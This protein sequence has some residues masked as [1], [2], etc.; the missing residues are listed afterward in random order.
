MNE[1][2]R[3]TRE[4]IAMAKERGLSCMVMANGAYAFT[5]DLPDIMGETSGVL[6]ERGWVATD[7]A[8]RYTFKDLYDYVVGSN[9]TGEIMQTNERT[10]MEIELS[11]EFYVAAQAKDPSVHIYQRTSALE[12]ENFKYDQVLFI[13]ILPNNK[14]CRIYQTLPDGEINDKYESKLVKFSDV[15][16]QTILPDMPSYVSA[17][18]MEFVMHVIFCW[19]TGQK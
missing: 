1:A 5:G 6:N 17:M 8:K 3:F 15:I 13:R 14:T 10:V 4:V 12:D 2:V 11:S 7:M 18:M 9:G 16:S 19:K